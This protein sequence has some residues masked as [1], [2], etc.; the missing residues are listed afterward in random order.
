MKSNIAILVLLAL[1]MSGRVSARIPTKQDSLD[2]RRQIHTLR[3]YSKQIDTFD[4]YVEGISQEK[5]RRKAQRLQTAFG[6]QLKIV[7]RNPCS[8]SFSFKNFPSIQVSG[9][10]SNTLRLITWE[11]P[12]EGTGFD[13]EFTIAQFQNHDS[14]DIHD[15]SNKFGN[16]EGW[17]LY[18]LAKISDTEYFLVIGIDETSRDGSIWIARML[19][20]DSNKLILDLPAFQDKRKSIV[21]SECDRGCADDEDRMQY[22]PSTKMLTVNISC[23]DVM[24]HEDL[25]RKNHLYHL[26]ESPAELA[27]TDR[28]DITKFIFK[29]ED[30]TFHVLRHKGLPKK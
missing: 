7:L 19:A 28:G 9:D 14:I 30:R 23:C 12:Q 18:S 13:D 26:S 22:S 27:E 1:V 10:Q 4:W 8:W 15:L 20:L 2:F 25:I 6:N 5:V 21:I 3:T 29:I 24:N 17:K 11:F 16:Y